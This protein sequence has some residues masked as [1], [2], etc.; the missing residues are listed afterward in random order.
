[1]IREIALH[2]G[3]NGKTGS[4][5]IRSDGQAVELVCNMPFC[6]GTLSVNAEGA[7]ELLHALRIV[8]YVPPPW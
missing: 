8:L 3:A 4:I 2:V 7:R 6:Q 1:M 5:L